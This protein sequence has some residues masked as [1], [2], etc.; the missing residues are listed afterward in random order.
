MS[1]TPSAPGVDL[2]SLGYGTV[3]ADG[4]F[5]PHHQHIFNLRI[6]PALD[7]YRSNAVVYDDTFAMPREPASNPHGV[8]FE[9]KTTKVDKEQAFD[10]DWTTNRVVKMIN[11]NKVNKHSRKPIAYKVVG[12]SRTV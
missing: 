2:S 5:A 8:G 9:V 11:P 7:G 1:V 3:V 4:V 10:L 6:D 12:V